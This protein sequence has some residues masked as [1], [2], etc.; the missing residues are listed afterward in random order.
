MA[1]ND[2]IRADPNRH[3]V[4]HDD[5]APVGGAAGR[6]EV[7]GYVVA[8]IVLVVGGMVVRTF[9]L[10]WIVGPLTVVLAVAL[11]SASARERIR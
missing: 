9:V 8:V 2:V 10:N 4:E 3:T 5:D 7:A 6:G 1:G 11:A